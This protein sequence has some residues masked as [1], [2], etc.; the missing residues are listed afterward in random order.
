MQTTIAKFIDE[1]AHFRRLRSSSDATKQ[2]RTSTTHV[3]REALD[4]HVVAWSFGGKIFWR[5]IRNHL[6][7]ASLLRPLPDRVPGDT[8]FWC[9]CLARLLHR[10]VLG[11]NTIL[12]QGDYTALRILIKLLRRALDFPATQMEQNWDTSGLWRHIDIAPVLRS[13]VIPVAC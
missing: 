2:M 13:R 6:I 8:Q 11:Q 4:S 3:Y 7:M 1:L 5:T 12:Y 9:G 10:Q